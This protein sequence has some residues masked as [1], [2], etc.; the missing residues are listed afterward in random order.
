[1]FFCTIQ[2]VYGP[3]KPRITPPLSADG[4]T[5]LKEKSSIGARWRE[6]FSTLL[7]K[8]STVDP[9]VLNQIPQKPVITSLGLPPLTKN[10]EGDQTHQ[11]GKIPWGGRDLQV[12]L[13]AGPRN[14]SLTPHQ[15]LGRGGC[16]QRI[17]ECH[18]HFSVQEQGQ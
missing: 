14:T 8:P 18:I 15:H 9:T 2:E 4:S 7:N 13:S 1:M 17:Q 10:F 11:L 3:T 6:H 12:N 16:A 5:L